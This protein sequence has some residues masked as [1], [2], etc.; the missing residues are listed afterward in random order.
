[1]ATNLEFDKKVIELYKNGLSMQKVGEKVGKSAGTILRILRKYNIETRT[2]GGIR[3]LPVK[4]I[5]DKYNI[6]KRTLESIGNDYSVTVNTI[7]KVILD[8]GG[9]IRTS[10]ESKNPFFNENYFEVIDTEAKAYFLGFLIADGCVI[11][12]NAAANHP[13]Y[14]I[15]LEL[16]EC[17][18]YILEQLK[19]ELKLTSTNLYHS[20]RIKGNSV[21]KTNSLSWY[22]TK[23]ANDLSQYGVVSRKTSTVFLPTL[24]E[25]LMPHLIRGMIDGDGSITISHIEGKPHLV[26]YF[27][28]NEKCV[29]QVRNYLVK[30]LNIYNV[31]VVK[32]NDNLSQISWASKNDIEKIKKYLYENANFYLYRKFNKFKELNENT[33]VI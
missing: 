20:E 25:H 13:N 24:K 8:N 23:M 3:Q 2:K 9:K 11:E 10:S 27:C 6:E 17:D 22:S 26:V 31:K 4:E 29:T 18:S 7:K 32:V 15:S 19:Q 12:P 16:Q 5:L 1:M 21:S 28:G 14:K 30:Q 33:E